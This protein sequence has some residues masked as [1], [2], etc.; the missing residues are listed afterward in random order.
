MPCRQEAVQTMKHAR[1]QAE[2]ELVVLR[3]QVDGL[4]ARI[5][6]GKSELEILAR[7]VTT[8]QTIQ[9]EG[10]PL[11]DRHPAPTTSIAKAI[12]PERF[13]GDPDSE[14]QVDSWIAK[15]QNYFDLVKI[16]LV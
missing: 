12:T 4:A 2:Q 7:Q 16:P 13:S 10:A 1:W 3:M 11:T 15:L 6:G 8:N 9:V 14:L 5:K